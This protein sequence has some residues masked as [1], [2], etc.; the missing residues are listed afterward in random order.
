MQ[1][2]IRELTQEIMVISREIEMQN[3]ERVTFL[4]YDQRAKDLAAELT[5]LQ[6]QLADYNIVIDKMASDTDNIIIEQEA[7]ELSRS[8]D[9]TL[10]EIEEMFEKRQH[11]DKHMRTIEE[12]IAL[13]RKNAEKIVEN[14]NQDAR[15]KYDKLIY[16]KTKL[17]EMIDKIQQ[18]SVSLS[19]EKMTLEGRIALSQVKQ[20][21][22]RLQTKI[23]ELTEKRAKLFEEDRNKLLPEV[24][25]DRILQKVKQDNVDIAASER[26]IFE[27]EKRTVEVEQELEQIEINIDEDLSEKLVKYKELRKRE[28]AMEDFM[29]NFEENK[30]EE[31]EKMKKMEATIVDYLENISSEM[32]GEFRLS[33]NHELSIFNFQHDEIQKEGQGFDGLRQEHI[34]LRKML[35]KIKNLDEK[36]KTE[37][38]VVAGKIE[39]YQSELVILE[40]LGGLK[41]KSKAKCEELLGQREQLKIQQ[42]ACDRKLEIVQMEF[43]EIE[44]RLN[45]SEIYLQINALESKLKKL[46]ENNITMQTSIIEKN[47]RMNYL[48]IKEH[49]FSLR[50]RYNSLLTDSIN[51]SIY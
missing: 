7:K 32:D 9:A 11:K 25:K 22:V 14:M 34:R 16:H 19:I 1:L 31:L 37:L 43:N 20:E 15:E 2:K 46:K 40:D 17:Q 51:K 36:L 21:A 47:E 3:K 48:P 12:S 4:H 8:N 26:R 6:C 28:E 24:E 41:S 44:N 33:N 45:G 35:T 23:I 18:Q 38:K 10:T 30:V 29:A 39:K 42:P 49:S 13:E 50:A 5:D 27:I